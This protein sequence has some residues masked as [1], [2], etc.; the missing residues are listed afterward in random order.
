MNTLTAINY[1]QSKFRRDLDGIT[2]HP[3]GSTE[4]D[5]TLSVYPFVWNLHGVVTHAV[6]SEPD[7]S[8]FTLDETE[9][10]TITG[11]NP[12]HEHDGEFW[13][14]CMGYAPLDIRP[15]LSR[16]PRSNEVPPPPD[17]LAASAEAAKKVLS[18]L[19]AEK[20]HVANPNQENNPNKKEKQN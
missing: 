4:T 6:Y 5:F 1:P 17:L 16:Y 20:T 18:K 8:S 19:Q 9:P 12:H 15:I 14:L 11:R 3:D 10:N 2:L 13:L 7:G